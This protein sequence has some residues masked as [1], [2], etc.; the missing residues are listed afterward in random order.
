MV[1]SSSS[2]IQVETLNG[3]AI[4]GSFAFSSW[5]KFPSYN[6]YNILS[7]R[8]QTENTYQIEFSTGMQSSSILANIKDK[9]IDISGSG[10]KINTNEWIYIH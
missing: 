8:E 7:C 4:T 2:T 9:Q 5:V 1:V 3:A 6:D 10:M